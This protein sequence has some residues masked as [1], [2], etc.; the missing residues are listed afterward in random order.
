VLFSKYDSMYDRRQ[1]L[2]WIYD[3][4]PGMLPFPHHR[5][6]FVLA[7]NRA[8]V[9]IV[10]LKSPMFFMSPRDFGLLTGTP[11]LTLHT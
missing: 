3:N 10:F 7:G 2:R 6:H 4:G 8:C 5:A 11:L 9:N 1:V